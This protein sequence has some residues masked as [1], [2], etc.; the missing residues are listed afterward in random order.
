[1]V[2]VLIGYFSQLLFFQVLAP[3]NHPKWSSFDNDCI[4]NR[5]T[6]Q[7][8]ETATKT[9]RRRRRRTA[10]VIQHR[11]LH[12]K[13]L[14]WI[15]LSYLQKYLGQKRYSKCPKEEIIILTS[16]QPI[17]EKK[18]YIVTMEITWFPRSFLALTLIFTKMIFREDWIVV[19]A[20]DFFGNI[21]LVCG[22]QMHFWEQ[23]RCQIELMQSPPAAE[24]GREA[25]FKS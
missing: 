4:K 12:F 8:G 22:L 16:K 21:V 2:C 15:F 3:T 24:I 5:F 7:I 11:K 18:R 13:Q 6:A 25:N 9:A 1:M 19:G 23:F 10:G 20:I 14:H 17:Y